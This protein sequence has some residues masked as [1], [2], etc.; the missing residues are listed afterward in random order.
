[1]K[2]SCVLWIFAMLMLAVGMSSCGSFDN[3]SQPTEANAAEVSNVRNSGCMNEPRAE[4]L[5]DKVLVMKKDGDIITCELQGYYT[6]C[7]AEYFDIQ[8]EYAKGKGAPDSLFVDV[9]PVIPSEADCTCPFTVYFTIRDMRADS[10]YLSCWLYSGMVSF[11]E[12][13]EV[14]VE[15]SNELVKLDD[16]S[17]YYL[18][19]PS[20]QAML[21]GMKIEG[22]DEYRVPSTVNYNGQEYNVVSFI[23]D[24]FYG[25]EVKKLFLPKTIQRIGEDNAEF[26]N[27]FN[28]AFPLLETIEVEPGSR[29][30][31]L[32]DGVLYSCD[33]K[34][35]YCLPAASKRTSYTV[36]DGVERIC[37]HA[38]ANCTNLKSIRLPESVSVIRPYAFESCKNLESIYILGKLDR[39]MTNHWSFVIDYWSYLETNPTSMPTLFVPES[40]IAFIKTI[41]DGTVL[42]LQE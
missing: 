2:K 4:G 42:P 23:G 14:R 37:Q 32:V 12:S 41:Y 29:M 13:N 6:N 40:E 20:Q 35:L 30:F 8:T 26:K 38:F 19:M 36:V 28:N 25:K 31:S 22:K 39:N 34:S 24:A 7:A 3:S 15:I 27:A 5:P 1:M 33:Q 11:K 9:S 10:F 18:Y 17:R 16:D 21:R